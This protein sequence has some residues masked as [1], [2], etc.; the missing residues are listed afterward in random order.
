MKKTRLL[1]VLFAAALSLASCQ[2]KPGTA[3]YLVPD[4]AGLPGYSANG[5]ESVFESKD[6]R[7]AARQVRKNDVSDQLLTSLLEKD[8]IILSMTL[9]NRSGAKVIYKPNYTA[10]VNKVDYLKPLD[11]TDLY[12][13]G[14][15]AV[16]NLKGKFFDLDVTLAP[17]AKTTGLLIFRPVSKDARTAVLEV[18]ELYVGTDTTVFSLPFKM[19]SEPS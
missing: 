7:A 10:V 17:G 12:E 1:F 8:Y 2:P 18:R 14:E 15:E 19:K 13:L 3:Y 6:I 5:A 9:E 11:Y 4:A 16:D